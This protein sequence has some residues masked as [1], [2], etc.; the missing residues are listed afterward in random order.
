MNLSVWLVLLYLLAIVGGMALAAALFNLWW[1]LT[2][3]QFGF[4]LALYSI[5]AAAGLGPVL[6]AALREKGVERRHGR[7]AL[8]LGLLTTIICGI[9]IWYTN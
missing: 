6:W 4:E 7:I 5:M 2:R 3:G 8:V 1:L 9:L